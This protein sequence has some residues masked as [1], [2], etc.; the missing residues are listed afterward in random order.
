MRTGRQKLGSLLLPSRPRY[1][2]YSITCQHSKWCLTTEVQTMQQAFAASATMLARQAC[3]AG[4]LP[5]LHTPTIACADHERTGNDLLCKQAISTQPCVAGQEEAGAYLHCGVRLP[6]PALRGRP[7][8]GL[9]VHQ[10]PQRH[11]QHGRDRNPHPQQAAIRGAAPD[12]W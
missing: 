5:M 1:L 8:G 4:A 6:Q 9:A 2:F 12:L 7:Q 11:G 10:Q 3:K